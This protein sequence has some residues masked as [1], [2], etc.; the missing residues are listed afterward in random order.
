MHGFAD[1]YNR[2]PLLTGGERDYINASFIE[3]MSY[4]HTYFKNHFHNFWVYNLY[5]FFLLPIQGY[6]EPKKYI[7]AQGINPLI[8]KIVNSDSRLWFAEAHSKR[9]MN[10]H[11]D[12]TFNI[13]FAWQT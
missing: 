3:V 1:D 12:P 2:V 13:T 8:K 5:K 9:P 6:R 7:A 10:A 11:F 4:K